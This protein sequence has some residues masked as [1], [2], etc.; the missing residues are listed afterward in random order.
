[1]IEDLDRSRKGSNKLVLTGSEFEKFKTAIMHHL[2]QC[3]KE[4]KFQR[5]YVLI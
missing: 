3:E 1:M 5:L 2:I 4:S